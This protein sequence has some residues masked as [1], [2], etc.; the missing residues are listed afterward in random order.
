MDFAF[1]RRWIG[2]LFVVAV[3]GCNKTHTPEAASASL[4]PPKVDLQD[5][6]ARQEPRTG[7]VE[8]QTAVVPASHNAAVAGLDLS[9]I[10]DE[11]FAAVIVHPRQILQKQ[12][13]AGESRTWLDAAAGDLGISLPDLEQI[14][15]LQGAPA[16]G[17]AAEGPSPLTAAW[18]FRFTTAESRDRM[19]QRFLGENWRREVAHQDLVYYKSDDGPLA[20]CAP[21]ERTVLLASQRHMKRAFTAHP[22]S[23]LLT[24]LAAIEGRPDVAAVLDAAPLRGLLRRAKGSERP[25][26]EGRDSAAAALSLPS[27][28]ADA[29]PRLKEATFTADLAE[30]PLARLTLEA[31]DSQGA[32]H[33]EELAQGYR[34][35][36][37]LL[38]PALRGQWVRG[39]E[40]QGFAP[41]FALAS[42]AL[43]GVTTTRN[44]RRVTVEMAAPRGLASLP[45]TLE[46]AYLTLARGNARQER[47]RRLQLIGL[48]MHNCHVDQGSFPAAA[49]RDIAGRPLLSWRVHLLP[50]L[51]EEDLYRQ[52][53]LDQ[54][55][56]SPHNAPLLAKIP[57]VYQTGATTPGQT[58]IVAMI[59]PG[60]PFTLSRGPALRDFTD[61]ADQTILLVECGPDRAV[62][63]TQPEDLPFDP[64]NPVAALGAIEAEGFLA[65]FGD[66]RVEIIRPQITAAALQDLLTHAGGESAEA[67]K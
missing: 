8:D 48:A 26:A 24:R 33:L 14:C 25:Q 2:T 40:G 54:P 63:W 15:F 42:D 13:I 64:A 66:G 49:S 51:G 9:Y 62:P 59:G 6:V 67:R 50:W 30:T 18:I 27:P 34:G 53:R 21:D 41:L 43:A 4:T 39:D 23:L 12:P 60:T 5:A 44:V 17:A 38:L 1:L 28:L 22:R 61:G 29:L 35:T 7:G 32:I 36:A 46:S 56:D 65:L 16:A 52:F 47:V 10:T 55:W 31:E 57:A 58:R 3:A 45:Q 11:Y 19:L 20:L 37:S